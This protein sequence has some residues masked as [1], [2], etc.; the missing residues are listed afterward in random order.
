MRI[1]MVTH[2]LPSMGMPS[3]TGVV[4][5]APVARQV[6]SLRSAGVEVDLLQITGGRGIKYLRCVSRLW[7]LASKVDLIHAHYGSA[8][9]WRAASLASRWWFPS[10]EV[11]CW[12]EKMQMAESACLGN[13]R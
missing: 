8:D 1:L 2:E 13:S 7:A 12:A 3:L 9:G 5:L 11:I 10:W 6:E 4:K